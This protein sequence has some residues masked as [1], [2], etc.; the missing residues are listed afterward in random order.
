MNFCL[1]GIL[2]WL[3]LSGG[4]QLTVFGSN[5]LV[6]NM[7]SM[8]TTLTAR[9]TGKEKIYYT[10]RNLSQNYV[11]FF[12]SLFQRLSIKNPNI[13]VVLVIMTLKI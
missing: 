13:I 7:R 11:E 9:E 3:F 1:N 12:F 5:L 10:V 2:S 6:P 4:V 8:K